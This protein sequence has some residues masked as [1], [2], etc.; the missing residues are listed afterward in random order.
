MGRTRPGAVVAL[1]TVTAGGGY[2]WTKRHAGLRANWAA[3]DQTTYDFGEVRWGQQPSH[4][5]RIRNVSS[6]EAVLSRIEKSCGCADVSASD[7][8]ILPGQT[9]SVRLTFSPE[10]L[11][12]EVE[13]PVL[14]RTQDSDRPVELRFRANVNPLL[15]PSPDRI[16]FGAVSPRARAAAQITL[17]NSSG[18]PVK[19]TRVYSSS[20]FV[21]ATL[22]PQASSGNGNPVIL[23]SLMNP[24]A[25]TLKATV[26]VRTSLAARPEIQIPVH[27]EVA[28]PWRMSD[29]EFFF[30]FVNIDEH[31]RRGIT[32]Q[33]LPPSEIAR[34]RTDCR[35]ARVNVGPGSDANSSEVTV[36]LNPRQTGLGELRASVTIEPKDNSAPC[37]Q[38]P[39]TGA[40][41]EPSAVGACCSDDKKAKP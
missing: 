1:L 21:G 40:I 31:P 27:A 3:V 9:G 2:T 18:G 14:I 5:F 32:I 39:L 6:H 11:M 29:S 38:L 23:C 12:G 19:I 4:T 8:K 22:A 16:D 17:K 24:P 37:L 25:G 20:E 41:E 13:R 28:C 7:R 30:G 15:A 36:D 33:G 10:G 34:I 26:S 35:G